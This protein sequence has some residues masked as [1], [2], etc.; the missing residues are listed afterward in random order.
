MA[1]RGHAHPDGLPGRAG[2]RLL[3][4]E[5]DGEP[6]EH[7]GRVAGRV[8][9]QPHV[10]VPVGIPPAPCTLQPRT[11]YTPQSCCTGSCKEPYGMGA[12]T[13][14]RLWEG[15]EPKQKGRQARQRV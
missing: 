1:G 13:P 5:E 10:A 3:Q 8:R 12:C 2:E 7:V 6:G 9:A 15:T 14:R 11:S 4:R